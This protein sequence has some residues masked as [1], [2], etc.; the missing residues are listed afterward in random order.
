MIVDADGVD[1]AMPVPLKLP[2]PTRV[3]F[4]AS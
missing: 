4:A 1:E 2:S 3:K